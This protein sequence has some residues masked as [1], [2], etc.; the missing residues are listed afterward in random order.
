M[1]FGDSDPLA[2]TGLCGALLPVHFPNDV[3]YVAL[4]RTFTTTDLLLL[5]HLPNV[6]Q[7]RC[8]RTISTHELDLIR[9]HVASDAWILCD[10]RS[11]DGVVRFGS[12]RSL[13]GSD[14]DLNGDGIVDE[15]DLLLAEQ[16]NR[17]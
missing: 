14:K 9:R 8:I 7:V 1:T 5:R 3:H 17:K 13:D 15:N 12:R 11:C 10:V 4:P 16:P 6:E 2:G